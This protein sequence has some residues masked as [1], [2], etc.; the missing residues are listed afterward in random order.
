MTA[1]LRYG[2]LSALLFAA[3]SLVAQAPKPAP[4]FRKFEVWVGTWAYEGDAKAT[5]IGPAA[6]VS[7]TQTGRF[8]MGGFGF[9]WKGEEKGL[10]GA[11]QWS[12]LD[13]YD[14]ATKSYPYFGVQNDGTVWSGANTIVG[15]VW[16]ATGTTT[17]KGVSY[18]VRADA[19][20][21]ADGKSW[22]FK[23]ELSS[24][25]KTWMPWTDLRLTKS[26][27]PQS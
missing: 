11:V 12:E 21:S 8:V 24:D 3:N 5:P 27:R 23:Q 18:K 17:A 13:A 7:G 15:N 25:G 10:F 6:R 16:K 19:T 9:E 26:V 20:P 4:E 22:T 14:A 2:T 1:V